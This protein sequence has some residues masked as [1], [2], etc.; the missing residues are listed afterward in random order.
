MERFQRMREE[1]EQKRKGKCEESAERERNLRNKE[2]QW[3]VHTHIPPEY[4]CTTITPPHCKSAPRFVLCPDISS[5]WG[6]QCHRGVHMNTRTQVFSAGKRKEMIF[7]IPL[8]WSVALMMWLSW[9]T[10][11][12]RK[13]P[14]KHPF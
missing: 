12:I 9:V 13:R 8:H 10:L 2:K 1:E 11:H 3:Q 7:K 6:H 14:F 4:S 5:C